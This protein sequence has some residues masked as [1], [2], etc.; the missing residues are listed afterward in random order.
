MCSQL[1]DQSIHGMTV[2]I[3][4][5]C[6]LL[7]PL[8]AF[9]TSFSP[10]LCQYLYFKVHFT[11][12]LHSHKKGERWKNCVKISTMRW[13]VD[14]WIW[15][16]I[17]FL[18]RMRWQWGN[19]WAHKADQIQSR[20][21]STKLGIEF[22]VISS[23]FT[24]LVLPILI[25]IGFRFKCWRCSSHRVWINCDN[26]FQSH[27]EFHFFPFLFFL[28]Y[29]TVPPMVWIQNQL[30]G[31]AIGQR[32]SLECQSE[33]FPKSINYWMKNDTIITQGEH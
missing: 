12:S 27:G 10:H 30:V 18:I 15:N 11:L 24:M 32:I 20:N 16:Q 9:S 5:C 25:V 2:E 17:L 6:F 14:I 31:A 4:K 1:S 23:L 19:A 22:P 28:L 26:P 3:G 8:P 33:A 29:T 21:E 7:P 13:R